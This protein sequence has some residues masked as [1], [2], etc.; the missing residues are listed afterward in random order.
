MM[1]IK[2]LMN[3]IMNDVKGKYEKMMITLGIVL[4]SEQKNLGGKP[5]MKRTVQVWINAADTRLSMIVTKLP[6]PRE[7][8]SI[9]LRM[10]M[11]CPWMMKRQVQSGLV[12]QRTFD[13]VCGQDGAYK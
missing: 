2:Q 3:A 12:I 13:D 11:R 5:L 4:K 7:A 10:C 6:S 1:P 8:Q 9:E